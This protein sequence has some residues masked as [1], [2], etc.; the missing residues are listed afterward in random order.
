M[1]TDSLELGHFR[2]KTKWTC[3]KIIVILLYYKI[4]GDKK[5]L[6]L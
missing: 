2:K 4:T 3:K 1:I 5:T 6:K